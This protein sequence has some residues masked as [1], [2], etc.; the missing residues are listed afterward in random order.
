MI[1][2]AMTAVGTLMLMTVRWLIPV[3]GLAGVEG[4]LVQP[5]AWI[6]PALAVIFIV[7]AVTLV[8]YLKKHGG[9]AGQL[10]DKP[11]G[12]ASKFGRETLSGRAAEDHA[13]INKFI[14]AA[15]MQQPQVGLD[16]QRAAS[17]AVASAVTEAATENVKTVVRRV[18]ATIKQQKMEEAPED[19]SEN[20][21]T[22]VDD[23][24]YAANRQ[25][26]RE[27]PL[28]TPLH[29]LPPALP[30]F[31]GRSFELAELYAAR[32]NPEIKIL[33]LQGLG[34]VGKTTLAVKLA[35]Q[36]APQYPDAQIYIDLKGASALPLPVVEAQAQ[37]IRAYLPTARLPENEAE[38]SRLYQ[39]VLSG[40]RALLLLDNAA[41][42]QQVGPLLPPD[43]RLAIITSR[44]YISLPGM[45]ASR[46][47][48]L[49]LSEARE[50]LGRMLPQIGDQAEK[51]AE[52]CGRLPLAMRLA[53]SALTQHPELNSEDYA[54][55][56]SGAPRAGE[57]LR[58][59]LRP[60]DAVLKTSY[61][62]L[63]PGLQKLWRLLAA[64]TDTF[65]V[66]AAA[67]VWKLNPARAGEALDRLMAYSLIER[68]RAT[69]RFRLHDLMLYFADTRLS[70][71]ERSLAKQR[72]SGHYQ[73]VLHEA[74]AL[75][76]Q[77]GEFMQQGL[78]LLD[79]EWHNIQAGQV[80]AA[81]NA[82]SDRAACDLCNS[83]PDAGKYVLDLRQH[84][85]ERIRWSEAALEGA[86]TLKRRKAAGR[87]L[88]ALGD[89]YADLS[90]AQHAIDCYEQAL[91]TARG[92]SDRRGE[93]E[94]LS[95]LGAAYF[96]GGGLIKAREFHEQA[97]EL[98]RTI[99]DSRVEAMALGNLG[100]THYAIGEARVA[101][102]LFDQQL[103]IARELGDRRNE[104]LA[105]GGLGVAHY[106][107]G[108]AERAVELLSRQ[109]AIT[110]EIGDRRGEASALCHLGSAYA[111]LDDPQHATAFQEQA[112][113]VAREIGDRRN[114]AN[115]LG[116]LGIAYHL[117]GDNE[118]AIQFLEMQR[119][120][121]AEIGDRRGESLALINLGEAYVSCER[122]DR[123]VEFLQAAFNLA[124]QV[125]D[126]Q[127][128][129]H[130]L[131]NLALALNKL[132]DRAQAIAQAETAME[133]FRIAEHPAA[134]AVEKQLGEWR[135]GK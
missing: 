79:L 111:S 36:L 83:Y 63:D 128:Q 126:I 41:N 129:G 120:L 113:A 28:T 84:P 55:R 44:Q 88:I 76:E 74:D 114:E 65:D 75:Y 69:G 42:A 49:P 131:L 103:R 106:S 9:K 54:Q 33:G 21:P 52:A 100:S 40:K 45:F 3:M 7:S 135:D 26:S 8:F 17:N 98:A 32:S 89:S 20:R 29:Q 24:V 35:H 107:L 71:D 37:I 59:V 82:E 16:N 87:H 132:G 23:A 34:G 19:W 130:A 70:P 60:I 31:A 91:E 95:G 94:A 104:S 39:S 134:K 14:R 115:A 27:I 133:L 122:A 102:V 124:R 109:L 78:S 119:K 22:N 46:L 67:A 80:W 62:L 116:G 68:N 58:P 72:H 117:C 12:D 18:T 123:A 61:E 125:G 38:L 25:L 110:R 92:I 30:D 2:L 96:L 105:L 90:E 127:G 1:I 86:K 101:T 11:L 57:P 53:A 56:L 66:H 50:L 85:R 48:S 99:K 112:L 93:A 64:F 121:A 13:L 43:G 5:L 15:S 73:S 6:T 51:I 77:G 10:F 108:N 47:D 81:T 118:V 97:L 4:E